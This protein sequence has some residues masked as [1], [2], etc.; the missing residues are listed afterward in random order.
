MFP[1]P[2]QN[3]DAARLLLVDAEPARHAFAEALCRCLAVRPELMLAFGGRAAVEALRTTG[4]D[5]VLVDLGSLADL[6]P[7]LEDAMARLVKVA[8]GALIVGL[9]DDRAVSTA[10]AVMRA[11]VHDVVVRPVGPEDL[12]MRLVQLAQR[13]GRGGLFGTT[14]VQPALAREKARLAEAS[15]Q[16][17]SIG[18]LLG[19][20]GDLEQLRH[21]IR[22][23]GAMTEPGPSGAPAA[24]PRP[25]DGRGRSA[26]LPMWQQEQRIIEEAIASCAGNIALAAAALEL[27]PSTIY[28]KRQAW[29]AMD[30][31]KGVA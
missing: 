28:R 11:G 17:E 27:S 13:H 20:P 19:W 21:V 3:S 31:A 5:L 1:C 8:E 12:A 14:P 26:I 30:D 10:L 23:L 29:A 22:Q 6:S 25:A 9:S 15:S 7:M 18:E 24:L 4:F 2:G 16:I